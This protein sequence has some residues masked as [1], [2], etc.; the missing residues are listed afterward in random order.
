MIG[1]P[2]GIAFTEIKTILYKDAYKIRKYPR[3]S[4]DVIVDV[5]ANI[6]YFS[7]TAR[8]L[9]PMAKI[10]ALEPCIETFEY[11]ASNMAGLNVECVQEALGKDSPLYFREMVDCRVNRFIE[12]DELGEEGYEVNS[13]SLSTLFKRYDIN[14]KEQKVYLKLDCEGGERFLINPEDEAL[15][16][17]IEHIGFELHFQGEDGIHHLTMLPWKTYFE[18]INR[19]FSETHNIEYSLSRKKNGYGTFNIIKKE[20]D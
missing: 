16:K 11:L 18:W 5:G 14:P 17:D 1:D 6:G 20:T 3:D 8:I 12:K 4:F 2:K 10:I 19:L 15:L 9:Q 13:I 7:M